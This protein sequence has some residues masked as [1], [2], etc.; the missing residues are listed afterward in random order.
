MIKYKEVP[1]K[2][3]RKP[4]GRFCDKCGCLIEYDK[5]SNRSFIL[6]FTAEGSTDGFIGS[7]SPMGWKVEDLC[8]DC[9]FFVRD[10]LKDNGI[11]VV[12]WRW[13]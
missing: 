13:D 5:P 10:L 3:I 7:P 8:D 11:K 2:P 12:E 9:A 1:Q 6:Q 4:I